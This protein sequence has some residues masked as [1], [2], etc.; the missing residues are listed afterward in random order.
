[1]ASVSVTP[2]ANLSNSPR[3]K[4]PFLLRGWMLASC[5]WNEPSVLRDHLHRHCVS[6]SA[7]QGSVRSWGVCWAVWTERRNSRLMFTICRAPHGRCWGEHTGKTC[8][9][10]SISAT[11][12]ASCHPLHAWRASS[13]KVLDAQTLGQGGQG[14]GAN[15]Q[16]TH[17]NETGWMHAPL[18]ERG[19]VA[20]GQSPPKPWH[21]KMA[22]GLEQ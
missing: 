20:D 12:R 21:L 4:S 16:W 5:S 13:T 8:D 9:V 18:G 22:R 7:W 2:L 14:E 11:P 3:R 15:P 6:P 1:M 10:G 17:R 19:E